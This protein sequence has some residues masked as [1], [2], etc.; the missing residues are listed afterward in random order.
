MN[1]LIDDLLTYSKVSSEARIIQTLNLKDL[2]TDV[3]DSLTSFIK[4]KDASIYVEEIPEKIQ[5]N[6]V[7]IRQ[8]FQNLITN[9]IKFHH[10]ERKP[11]VHI[12]SIE[13]D[14]HW[15]FEVKDNGIGVP[16]NMREKIFQLFK[17]I[18]YQPEHHG[19]G[20]GLALCKRIVDHHDGEIWVESKLGEGSS[21]YFTIK[22][23]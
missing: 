2:L 19:T 14:E 12:S 3:I 16:D 1:Q 11:I 9:A 22:K 10:P 18:H 8:L 20:I 5:A 13:Q 21:F 6:H 17:K 4:E 7:K 15:L 23:P